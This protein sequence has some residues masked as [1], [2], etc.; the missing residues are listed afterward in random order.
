MPIRRIAPGE[1]VTAAKL[2]EIIDALNRAEIDV[3]APLQKQNFNGRTQ[4]RLAGTPAM[5]VSVVKRYGRVTGGADP[6]PY[7]LTEVE[8]VGGGVFEDL[9]PPVT[10]YPVYRHPS[11][12]S[13][14]D[15]DVGQHVEFWE[16][17]NAIDTGT[18]GTQYECHPWGA[19][20]EISDSVCI[21]DDVDLTC[22]PAG[23]YLLVTEKSLVVTVKSRDLKILE[24]A[25][26]DCPDS[27]SGG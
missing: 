27:G 8:H 2:N 18:E 22:D 1:T 5:D 16:T 26:E 10:V 24:V 11:N 20:Y 14:P 25:K 9:D 23:L 6:G 12:L 17:L 7:T 4:I 3:A 13:T 15:I 21:V 19:M